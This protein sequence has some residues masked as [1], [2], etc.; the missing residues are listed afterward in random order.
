[1]LI[2][3]TGTLYSLSVEGDKLTNAA[4]DGRT[5]LA[6]P[7]YQAR[8]SRI[9]NHTRLIHTLLKVL[10]IHTYLYIVCIYYGRVSTRTLCL[11]YIHVLYQRI[12]NPPT[13]VCTICTSTDVL[14]LLYRGDLGPS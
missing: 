5:H 3:H 13:T 4:Q 11:Q 8:T 14:L 9:D 12:S 10:T 7:N 6:K 1:M 2:Q